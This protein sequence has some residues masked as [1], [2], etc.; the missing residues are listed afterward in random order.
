MKSALPLAESTKLSIIFRVEPGCLGP[1]GSSHISAFCHFAQ[2]DL[3]SFYSNFIIWDIVPRND[4]SLAEI[5]YGIAGKKI[6]DP[7]AKKYLSMFD[8]NLDD[9]EC[10][11]GDKLAVL[12]G[13]Y[14]KSTS[15]SYSI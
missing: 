6:T 14:M 2:S 11:L 12:I 9:I 10:S 15:D 8:E 3:N 5:E 1:Q 13:H 7:Q 4:K